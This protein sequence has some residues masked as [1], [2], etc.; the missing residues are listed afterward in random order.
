MN[1]HTVVVVEMDHSHPV[2]Q[3][4]VTEVAVDCPEARLI[5]LFGALSAELSKGRVVQS[6][7]RSQRVALVR[8]GRPVPAVGDRIT[9]RDLAAVGYQRR[10]ERELVVS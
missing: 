4:T 10:G 7:E 6:A 9:V 2:A 1:K 3:G 5:S 8:P